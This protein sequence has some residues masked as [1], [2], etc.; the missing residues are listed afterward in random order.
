MDGNLCPPEVFYGDHP[1]LVSRR[2]YEGLVIV[3]TGVQGVLGSSRQYLDRSVPLVCGPALPTGYLRRLRLRAG[4]LLRVTC[5]GSAY[6]RVG[7]GRCRV[8]LSRLRLRV[9]GHRATYGWV[10][11]PQRHVGL[12]SCVLEF[13]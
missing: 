6:G 13:L 1:Y 2:L 10:G 7:S 3:Q 4:G 11:E 9:G 5:A 8:E 12:D